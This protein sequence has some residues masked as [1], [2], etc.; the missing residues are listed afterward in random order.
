MEITISEQE[1]KKLIRVAI[2]FR[3][4]AYAPYSGFRVGA[5][6]LAED[7]FVIPGCNVENASYGAALCA[8]RNAVGKAV[9]L[10]YRNFRAIAIAGG[11]K[12]GI[13]D[14]TYP[15]GICRQV[16]AEFAG[17]TDLI[18]I[19]AKSVTDYKIVSLSELLPEAFSAKDISV[20]A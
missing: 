7:G 9:G 17:D 16:L 3:E 6:L 14:Y 8:E 1:I 12:D 2:G 13:S 18:V 10:G 11:M 19:A 15:C 4:N 20:K 5:A